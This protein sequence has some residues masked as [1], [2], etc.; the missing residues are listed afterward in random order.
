MKTSNKRKAALIILESSGIWRSNYAPPFVRFLWLMGFEVPPPH[1]N[2]FFANALFS[3]TFFA[4]IWGVFMWIVV[5]SPQ[6][7]PLTSALIAAFGAGTFFGL[8][9]SGYYA[10]GR[11]KHNFPKWSEI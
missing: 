2:N 5:W 8:A 3:G 11:R 4:A 1:F 6:K 7:M 10:Y 9:L